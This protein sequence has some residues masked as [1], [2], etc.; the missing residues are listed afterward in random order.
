M[1]EREPRVEVQ[2][3]LRETLAFADQALAGMELRVFAADEQGHAIDPP[4]HADPLDPSEYF[5]GPILD[6]ND[7]TITPQD[8]AFV[9]GWIEGKLEGSLKDAAVR[10]RY[11]SRDGERET[12]VTI[13]D[14]PL[15][16]EDDRWFLSEWKK[17][18]EKP[19]YI[20]WQEE[21][22][23]WQIEGADYE[24]LEAPRPPEAILTEVG[25]TPESLQGSDVF[26]IGPEPLVVDGANV[27][28]FNL[29]YYD[30]FDDD[31]NIEQGSLDHAIGMDPMLQ[32]ALGNPD[33]ERLLGQVIE[34]L[35]QGEGVLRI[36]KPYLPLDFVADPESVE[37]FEI[38]Y[39]AAIMDIAGL[40]VRA[41]YDV[42]DNENPYLLIKAPAQTSE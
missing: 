30:A 7:P 6:L 15:G 13:F 11:I 31:L 1:Q 20:L 39:E 8:E 10:G 38:G 40:S 26:Y 23:D 3:H 25:L 27:S 18:G 4:E 2:P 17:T 24:E 41:T 16:T 5:S 33:R 42:S 36:A 29:E 35:K 21:V 28:T 12:T 22:Y 32:H 37:D 34:A 14:K 9:M 19:S